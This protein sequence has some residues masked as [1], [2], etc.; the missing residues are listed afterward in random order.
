VLVFVDSDVVVHA[1]SLSR[2]ER[3]LA[4]APDIAAVF[5]AYDDIPSDPGFVSQ[6]RN[7]AHAFVHERSSAD[8]VTS[9]PASARFG[10]PLLVRSAALRSG[11]AVRPSKTLNLAIVLQRPDSASA[12]TRPSAGRT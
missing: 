4:D 1:D 8:A 6:T 5:G 7:L 11:I 2:L 3:Q 9:G 10:P 12:S